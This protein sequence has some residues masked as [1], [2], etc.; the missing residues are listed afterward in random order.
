[1]LGSPD[2]AALHVLGRNRDCPFAH[3]REEF[4]E[5]HGILTRRQEAENRRN[6]RYDLTLK[7]RD[8]APILIELIR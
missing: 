6:V 3:L 4:L 8:L 2:A 1:M 5:T 7:G